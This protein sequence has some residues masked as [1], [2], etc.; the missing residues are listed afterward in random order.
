MVLVPNNIEKGIINQALLRIRINDEVIL[1]AFFSLQFQSDLIQLSIV[2]NTQGGAIP[3]LVSM[4]IFRKTPF[5]LPPFPEQRKIADILSTWDEAIA[6]TE[7]LIAALGRRKKGL[8]QCLLTADVR[9]PEFEKQWNEVQLGDVF[10]ERVER[11]YESLP[12]LSVTESGIR[13][14]DELDRRDSSNPD[15]SKYL[16]ICP[17]D[18]GYNTMRMWQGRSALS[19]YEGIVS[20][21]YTILKPNKLIDVRY[22][23]YLFKFQPMIYTF[24]R[25]SQGLVSDTWSIKVSNLCKNSYQNT[26]IRRTEANC[27]YS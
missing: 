26:R 13:Y 27:R 7:Q 23:A 22:M 9:F 12:L 15:K 3:N 1:P 2:D 24:Y 8:M 17:G 16:R 4:A 10:S 19:P 5:V 20:P 25:Y 11:G 21:A 14:R 18:I 6:K